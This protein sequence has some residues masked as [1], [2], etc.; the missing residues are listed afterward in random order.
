MNTVT[1]DYSDCKSVSEIIDRILSEP[2]DPFEKVNDIKPK[3]GILYDILSP[4]K[5][6][7]TN[8]GNPYY[9]YK[10]HCKTNKI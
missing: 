7:T 5:Y 9:A 8:I 6:G 10:P 3:Q 2:D 1:Y 4:Q